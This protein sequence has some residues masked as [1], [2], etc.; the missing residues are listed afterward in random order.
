MVDSEHLD[1][2]PIAEAIIDIRVE[3]TDDVTIDTLK[4]ITAELPDTY[5]DIK[6]QKRV[7][8]E[9]QIKMDDKPGTKVNERENRQIGFICRTR[10]ERNVAQIQLSGFAF[11]EL[12]PYSDWGSFSEKAKE[13]W[14][15]YC[16]TTGSKNFPRLA[17]R[18]INRMELPI[19]HGD[20]FGKYLTSSPNIPKNLPQMFSRFLT[21]VTI[22]RPEEN[23]SAHVTQALMAPEKEGF[24]NVLLDIDVFKQNSDDV[25]LEEIWTTLATLKLFENDIF[26][27]YITEDA[28][29]LFK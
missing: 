4:Q 2:A 9:I 12:K 20:D 28:K 14:E 7:L 17:V 10:D 16:K 19:A 18:Y 24:V 22:A 15:I 23:I 11:S 26:F 8:T 21:R 1:N 3:N 27:S 13:I 6:D 5:S 29:E 25:T